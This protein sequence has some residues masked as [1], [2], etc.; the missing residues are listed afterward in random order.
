MKRFTLFNR[1]YYWRMLLIRLVVNMFALLLTALIVPNIYFSDRRV[2]VWIVVALGLGLL[3]TLIKPII[4]LLT[5]QFFFATGGL[6]VILINAIMLLLLS[7]IF[8]NRLQVDGFFWALVGGAMLGLTS[9]FLESL[10]GLT[11]PIV[12]EKYPELRQRVKDR[13]FYRTQA[14]LAKIDARK[15]A[16]GMKE[17]ATAKVLVTGASAH[18][19]Q[20]VAPEII[21]SEP[22]QAEPAAPDAP[23]TNKARSG[24]A[25]AKQEG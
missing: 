11:P 9:A 7:W 14:E 24:S 6:V 17:L 3:N 19:A 1:N 21:G 8:P 15:K 23:D 2:V 16:G 25:A 4:Q 22:G 10:L 5:L 20:Y 13:Q 18:V 12:S